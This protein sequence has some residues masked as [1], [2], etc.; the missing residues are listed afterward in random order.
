MPPDTIS[1]RRFR[2]TDWRGGP[3]GAGNTQPNYVVAY[4][5][6]TGE[7]LWTSDTS[8]GP[9]ALGPV[10]FMSVPIAVNRLL[11][12]PC[13]VN[14]DLYVVLLDPATGKIVRHVYLCSTGGG[15][16]DSLYAR[17]PTA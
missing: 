6:A 14:A 9:A 7:A 12:A 15:P 1:I 5:P 8:S 2:R 17:M 16:F 13:R 4:S 10:E 11:L 3:L